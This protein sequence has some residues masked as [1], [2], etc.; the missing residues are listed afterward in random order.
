MVSCLLPVFLTGTMATSMQ[1]ELSLGAAGLGLAVALYRLA[2]AVSSPILG[3]R[4]DRIGATRSLRIATAGA[5][6]ASL[7]IAVATAN[8]LMLTAWLMLAGCA[9]ALAQPAANR[10]LAVGIDSRRLGTAFGIKQSAPPASSTL[11]GLAV[12]L[13]AVT[14]GWRWAFVAAALLAAGLS[15]G[16]RPVPRAPRDTAG[17]PGPDRVADRVTILVLA[18]A[19]GLGTSVS[20]SVTTFF[21]LGMVG[22]GTSEVQAGTLLAI[23]GTAAIAVRIV[24]GMMA[25]RSI[26]NHLRRCAFLAGVGAIGVAVLAFADTAPVQGVAVILALGGIWGFNGVF[27]FALIDA[28]PRSPGRITGAVSPGALLGSTIGPILFGLLA[29]SAGYEV[30]FTVFSVIAVVTAGALL[31]GDRRLG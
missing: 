21:V 11:A 31:V 16:L 1:A 9:G 2:G 13:V 26:G 22:R 14:V 30:G 15:L 6:I 20:S 17:A 7:G 10:L 8:T 29:E 24:A 23:A 28:F 25:D 19:F 27:W 12:P 5:A 18:V 4:A 3:R